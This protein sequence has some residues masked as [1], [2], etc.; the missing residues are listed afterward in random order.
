MKQLAKPYTADIYHLERILNILDVP[1]NYGVRLEF[2]GIELTKEEQVSYFATHQE[3]LSD[4][5]KKLELLWEKSG[6]S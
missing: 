6:Y 2:L 3:Q 1:K 4:I 5:N